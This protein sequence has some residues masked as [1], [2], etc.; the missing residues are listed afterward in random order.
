MTARSLPVP[1][2][3]SLPLLLFLCLILSCLPWRGAHA[4]TAREES[5]TSVANLYRQVQSAMGGKRYTEALALVNEGLEQDPNYTPLLRQHAFLLVKLG[6]NQEAAKAIAIALAAMPED[7]ELNLM[8]VD[9]I[10]AQRGKKPDAVKQDLT[11]LFARTEPAVL[12]NL[13]SKLVARYNDDKRIHSMLEPLAISNTLEPPEQRILQTWLAGDTHK[14]ATMLK[15]NTAGLTSQNSRAPVY[16]ALSYLT[17]A[18][19][20][21]KDTLG[22][23]AELS[24]IAGTL[25]FDPDK[26]AMVKARHFIAAGQPHKAGETFKE[27]WKESAEPNRMAVDAAQA[28]IKSG[29]TANALSMLRAALVSSPREPYLQGQYLYMLSQYG[30]PLERDA[31]VKQL[32]SQGDMLAL[33]Y[34]EYLAARYGEEDIGPAGEARATLVQTLYSTT[35]VHPQESLAYIENSI[36]ILRPGSAAGEVARRFRKQGWE[37]WVAGRHRQAY[38]YWRDA[39]EIGLPQ[40]ED[41][42]LNICKLLYQQNMV[43][44]SRTLLNQHLPDTPLSA[45]GVNMTQDN[46][47]TALRS[48]L[49]NSS[50]GGKLASWRNLAIAHNAAQTGTPEE[51]LYATAALALSDPPPDSV[52]INSPQGLQADEAQPHTLTRAYY[53][54]IFTSLLQELFSQGHEDLVFSLLDSPVMQSLPQK[55]MA[56]A[57]ADMGYR[58]LRENSMEKSMPYLRAALRLDSAQPEANLALALA[59]KDAGRQQKSLEYLELGTKADPAKKAYILARMSLL[60]QNAPAAI[61]YMEEHVKRHPYDLA[62][63]Y[64]LFKLYMTEMDYVSARKIKDYFAVKAGRRGAGREA[65]AYEALCNVHLG[66]Y[67][68]AEKNLLRIVRANPGNTSAIIDLVAL[69]K[70]Q[71]RLDE[72]SALLEKSGLDDPDHLGTLRRLAETALKNN[73]PALAASYAAAYLKQNP[74]SSYM[75]F[76]YVETLIAQDKLDEAE[77]HARTVLARNDRHIGAHDA[78]VAAALKRGANLQAM[79]MKT[80]ETWRAMAMRKEENRHAAALLREKA[81]HFPYNPNLA[82]RAALQSTNELSFRYAFNAVERLLPLGPNAASG[83]WLFPKITDYSNEG[84][85][86]VADVEHHLT[87]AKDRY[88]F[89]D[90]QKATLQKE[91]DNTRLDPIPILL[92]IG[93]STPKQLRAL[94]DVLARQNARAALLV[95]EESF[96]EGTPDQWPPYS[97]LRELQATGRWE[98]ILTDDVSR[99][100]IVDGN[101]RLGSFWDSPAWLGG[102]HE[103]LEEMSG[104]WT[105]VL[106]RM[107]EKARQ[108][109]FAIQTWMYPGGDYG[110]NKLD[111][112]NEYRAAYAAAVNAHFTVCLVSA[113]SA[114]HLTGAATDRMPVRIFPAPLTNQEFAQLYENHPT[115]QAVLD[116]ARLA[117]WHRQTPRAERLFKKATEYGLS[118]S[119]I[120]FNR[121]A[122]AIIAG[123]VAQANIL[124]REAEA[125]APNNPRMD[126]LLARA[127][128]LKRPVLRLTPRFW[129][130]SDNHEFSEYKLSMSGHVTDRLSLSA[131]ISRLR[132]ADEHGSVHGSGGEVGLRYYPFAQHWFQAHIRGVALEGKNNDSFLEGDA[133]WHGVFATDFLSI[134]GIYSLAYSHEAIDT[135]E[136]VEKGISAD[137][138]RLNSSTRIL[139]WGVLDLDAYGTRRSDGNNSYGMSISPGYLLLDD[140]SVLIGYQCDLADSDRNPPEYYAPVN[141]QAHLAVLTVRHDLTDRLTLRGLAKFGKASNE[142]HNWRDVFRVGGSLTFDVTDNLHFD[143]NYYR[144]EL[145]GYKLNQ[146]SFGLQ[147]IF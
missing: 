65:A 116:E 41:F 132:W 43:A 16:S 97:L 110:H 34:G 23:S 73:D 3:P 113:S 100:V 124:A 47:W 81:E 39:L 2:L 114:Y 135:R 125:L 17:A 1:T 79:I 30:N 109:G 36:G 143:V 11:T 58:R 55:E 60:D 103:S 147:Y 57:Y 15:D 50:P 5:A 126:A 128:R 138:F 86:T 145:P 37:A 94:D 122:N 102:R 8:A 129:W 61:A 93:R 40:D 90:L 25:G 78:L 9:T 66:H 107:Q 53:G 12:P 140:P 32:R 27:F 77:E 10:L 91:T 83:I 4:E 87:R 59:E 31:Y 76:L 6:K 121:A 56:A 117:S 63:R 104:R 21:G 19:L 28:F 144:L 38:G 20:E 99:K 44:E 84:G 92:V 133:V 98:F 136:A 137:S 146:L 69:Y 96:V 82:L 33:R 74:H 120:T 68:Q 130:D 13:V 118:Q 141:Y 108:K 64:E 70:I 119:T 71:G 95:G 35:H 49:R 127:E 62:T 42:I 88:L 80:G 7:V 26:I 52:T 22:L 54:Q 115:R 72:A 85:F 134:N 106:T 18:S 29:D 46:D 123:D 139:N 89:V 24:D 14:A 48:S 101:G 131:G 51:I 111:A 142:S 112:D 67:E 75:H 105:S 45:L